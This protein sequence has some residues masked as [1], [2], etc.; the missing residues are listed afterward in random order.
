MRSDVSRLVAREDVSAENVENVRRVY[1]LPESDTRNLDDSD[2]IF[3]FQPSLN[4]VK[5]HD[6]EPR[7]SQTPCSFA[8]QSL[9]YCEQ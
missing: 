6:V 4:E 9:M 3:L 7:N 5:G 8:I 1:Q 2:Y